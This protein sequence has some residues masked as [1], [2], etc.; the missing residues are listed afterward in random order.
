MILGGATEI[1]D[2]D[3]EKSTPVPPLNVTPPSG[4]SGQN[5]GASTPQ[6]PLDLQ[7]NGGEQYQILVSFKIH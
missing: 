1:D 5:Q 4:G 2:D 6:E 7:P 3:D